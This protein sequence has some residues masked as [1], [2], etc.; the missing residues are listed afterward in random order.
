MTALSRPP[1]IRRYHFLTC[2]LEVT[3]S[4]T[5]FVERALGSAAQPVWFELT[6]DDPRDLQPGEPLVLRGDREQLV[7]LQK[8][9]KG[10]GATPDAMPPVTAAG[11]DRR[12]SVGQLAVGADEIVLDPRQVADLVAAFE[13]CHAELPFVADPDAESSWQALGSLSVRARLR[14]IGAIAAIAATAAAVGWLAIARQQA[15]IASIS[16]E[17]PE[18]TDS[19]TTAPVELDLVPVAPPRSVDLELQEPAAPAF[20][21]GRLAPPE[22]I[23]PPPSRP[24]LSSRR[25]SRRSVQPPAVVTPQSPQATPPTPA[26]PPPTP[27]DSVASVE[28]GRR[29]TSPVSIRRPQAPPR[30]EPQRRAPEVRR[31]ASAPSPEPISP[32]PVAI[33]RLDGIPQIGEAQRYFAARW[34]PLRGVE[35]PLSY[36]LV[37]NANGTLR[38][39]IPLDDADLIPILRTP[40]PLPGA[41]FV[42]PLSPQVARLEPQIL[43]VLF[44]DGRAYARAVLP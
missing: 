26:A 43:V 38:R 25:L 3:A 16:P 9:V 36:R 32:E 12:L 24:T 41:P 13:R 14:R 2:T 28:P 34:Q 29:P 39:A 20:A 8:A 4:A 42:S 35:Q 1:V 22:P 10:L 27:S 21:A 7:A 5:S 31:P 19:P 33:A 11:G 37:L 18:P 30:T 23:G 6:L 40:V 17:A 44:P 15:R